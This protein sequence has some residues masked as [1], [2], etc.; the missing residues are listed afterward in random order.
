[1]WRMLTLN[2]TWNECFCFRKIYS[3]QYTFMSSDCRGSESKYHW[4]L[5]AEIYQRDQN[6]SFP[7]SVC[8]K[9]QRYLPRD[10]KCTI[11]KFD[12]SQTETPNPL[13]WK[14]RIHA[15]IVIWWPL[16]MK[17]FVG[18]KILCQIIPT[19]YDVWKIKD[20]IKEKRK[21]DEIIIDRSIICGY[22]DLLKNVRAQK[23]YGIRKKNVRVCGYDDS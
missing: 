19:I 11:W 5:S 9:I 14:W 20:Q 22:D 10:W 8:I 2:E 15:A 7:F 21:N 13:N 6:R 23:W 4:G 16:I 3:F 1:M 17:I 18:T 12:T